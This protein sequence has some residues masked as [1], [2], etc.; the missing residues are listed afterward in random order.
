VPAKVYDLFGRQLFGCA[1][2]QDTGHPLVMPNVTAINDGKR[3]AL[4]CQNL[5]LAERIPRRMSDIRIAR[6][7][8]NAYDEALFQFGGEAEPAAKL[9]AHPSPACI[10][11]VH[12]GF[13]QRVDFVSSLGLLMQQPWHQGELGDDP[14]LKASLADILIVAAQIAHD[15]FGVKLEL[16]QCL[17]NALELFFMG[18]MTVFQGESRTKPG[19]GLP[20]RPV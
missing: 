10:D 11:A 14:I 13:M 15:P 8:V 2:D 17:D 5:A 18:I 1:A 6:K 4:I 12:P 7:A 9:R 16:F 19:V 20:Q 3:R